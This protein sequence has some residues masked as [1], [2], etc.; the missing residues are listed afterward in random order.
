[1][2]QK[3]PNE[4][5]SIVRIS[6]E[7]GEKPILTSPPVQTSWDGSLA[8]SRDKTLAFTRAL[9]LERDIFVA[10]LFGDLSSGCPPPIRCGA[11]RDSVFIVS[12]EHTTLYL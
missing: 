9:G 11:R 4:T 5:Y 7:T 10:S 1:V 12:I 6:V 3:A 2:E 8:P